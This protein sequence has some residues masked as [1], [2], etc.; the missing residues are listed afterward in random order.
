MAVLLGVCRL[1]DLL[2]HLSVGSCLLGRFASKHGKESYFRGS[3]GITPPGD[4]PNGNLFWKGL[5]LGN[6]VCILYLD[7]GTFIGS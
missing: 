5:S 3:R 7:F 4:D 2:V 1:E 6:L